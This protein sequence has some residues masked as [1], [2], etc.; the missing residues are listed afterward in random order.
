MSDNVTAF[1]TFK[2]PYYCQN[3]HH[4]CEYPF[5]YGTIVGAKDMR[6]KNCGVSKKEIMDFVA[7]EHENHIPG[8]LAKPL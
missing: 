2:A 7:E 3:C 8:Q 5:P 1:K 4:T 6:C